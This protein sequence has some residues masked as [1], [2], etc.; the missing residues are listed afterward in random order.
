MKR[1][2]VTVRQ[3]RLESLCCK[4]SPIGYTEGVAIMNALLISL[5]K[6]DDVTI[7]KMQSNTRHSVALSGVG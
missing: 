1:K 6:V 3:L 7:S 4:K 5:T 2:P